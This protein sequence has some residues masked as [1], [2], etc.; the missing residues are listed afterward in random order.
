MTVFALVFLKN[1]KPEK[2]KDVFN[3]KVT[4]SLDLF[5]MQSKLQSCKLRA[6]TGSFH[7]CDPLVHDSAQIILIWPL[8]KA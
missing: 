2:S 1:L 3:S 8:L 6:N 4:L 5:A 7:F